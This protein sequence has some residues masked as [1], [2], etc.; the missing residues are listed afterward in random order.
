[1]RPRLGRTGAAVAEFKGHA[2][3]VAR[4]ALGGEAIFSHSAPF[5]SVHHMQ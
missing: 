4:P 1:M 3:V 5:H 2:A